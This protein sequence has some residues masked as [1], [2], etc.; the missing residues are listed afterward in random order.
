MSKVGEQKREN[1]VINKISSQM[2][3]SQKQR[4]KEF[5]GS[6]KTTLQLNRPFGGHSRTIVNNFRQFL[7]SKAN[8][9]GKFKE[10]DYL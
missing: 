7:G 6:L 9:S 1:E 8:A 4:F 2:H 10:D 3:T 5:D